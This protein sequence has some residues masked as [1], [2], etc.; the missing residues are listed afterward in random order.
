MSKELIARHKQLLGSATL[1]YDDPVHIVRGEGAW[2][3][4]KQGKRYL[5]MYNNVPCVG[6]ANAH[7]VEAISRQMATLSVHSRYLHEGVLDYA[8]RQLVGVRN[9]GL[10]SGYCSHGQTHG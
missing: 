2:L 8:E 1:F 4:D 9:H 10:H 3:F 7:V 6:H 5:D